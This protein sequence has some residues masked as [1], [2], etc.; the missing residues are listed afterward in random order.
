MR[1]L[2]TLCV[3]FARARRPLWLTLAWSIAGFLLV[4]LLIVRQVSRDPDVI[5]PE[6][7]RFILNNADWALFLFVVGLILGTLPNFLHAW[8]VAHF[9]SRIGSSK[10]FF[11]NHDLSKAVG[12][13]LRL[14]LLD[15]A[16]SQPGDHLPS[17][18]SEIARQWLRKHADS[19]PDL[20]SDFVAK[21]A[22]KPDSP[23]K[24]VFEKTL[25]RFVEKRDAPVLAQG[26]WGKVLTYLNGGTTL[27]FASDAAAMDAIEERLNSRFG[28]A[29]WEYTKDDFV[30]G[31]A[32]SKAMDL[33]I[34]SQ[35]LQRTTA[36]AEGIG[37]LSTALKDLADEW[38]K[39]KDAV[40]GELRRLAKGQRWALRL[41]S[42]NTKAL[43]RI[44]TEIR[45]LANATRE[46]LAKTHKLL[47][48]LGRRGGLSP[49]ALPTDNLTA[50]RVPDNAAKFK[51]RDED[52]D[53]LHR[54]VTSDPHGAPIPVIAAPGVG[55]SALVTRY[56]YLHRNEFDH[57]W[58][59]RASNPEA[60]ASGST[61]E[62]SLAEL[63]DL[64][65]IE[66]NAIQGDAS[67]S[68][69]DALA[70]RVRTWLAR[71]KSDG[72][73]AR[74][75]LVLD[76]VDDYATI[77]RLKLP[78]PS[79][80]I[81]TARAAHLARDGVEAMQLDAL[82]PQD[83][84][85]VLRSRTARWDEAAYADP[86]HEVGELVGRNALALVYLSAVLARPSSQGPAKLRNTLQGALKAG[87][88]GPLDASRDQE[89]PDDHDQQVAEAFALFVEPYKGTSEMAVL[90]VAALCAPD[91]IAVGLVTKASGLEP[92][93]FDG[94]L[95]ELVGAGV[96]DFDDDAISIHRLTQVS[97]VGD[98]AQRGSDDRNA[99][100]T[101]LLDGL[102]EVF[103]WPDDMAGQ[104][105]DHLKTPARFL[106]LAHAESV[107]AHVEESIGGGIRAGEPISRTS[108]AES[109]AKAT[110]LES[111][112]ALLHGE[113]AKW[114]PYVGMLSAAERNVMSAIN[115][116]EKQTP[117]DERSLAIWYRSRASIRQLRGMLKEAEED[118]Q[119]SI[120]WGEKQTP[121]DERSLAID[122]ASRASIR[123]DRGMLEEAEE[124]I[125]KSI[126][127]GEKHTPRDER[128]LA[129]CYASRA[130]ILESRA[131]VSRRS[132][133]AT[134][135]D[136][137]FEKAKAD[138]D[139]AL[140]W[141][142][143][144]MPSDVRSI[145][146]LRADK[147]RINEAAA[148]NR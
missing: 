84:L 112:V 119:K 123:Q 6:S 12:Q 48:E 16:D 102:I 147:A 25:W 81:F 44:E 34:A 79:R 85:L 122:Y 57:V 91:N 29:L 133:D 115:W 99:A 67:T 146:I 62:R 73:H 86:L 43:D 7:A 23:Y 76:N 96:L 83:T 52:L 118:I 8:V 31:G 140:T 66:S 143:T 53:E 69:V 128:G 33:L 72:T 71:P 117:R 61:E 98:M 136:V 1:Y 103:R 101:R 93:A 121:R 131:L 90:D 20:W 109:S 55:K 21:E 14:I 5:L 135:A 50:A 42:A 45:G 129:I 82:S 11:S 106:A 13:S 113:M 58:W 59:V 18:S 104:H 74:H 97:V 54:R 41:L 40:E 27:P 60:R 124:D 63:L 65:G 94:A 145:A 9:N 107:I 87:Q 132:G 92:V 51:G 38:N 95:D 47:E 134:A 148:S 125:A 126:D 28:E 116:G 141:Y 56:V 100:L 120:D 137:L 114:L 2:R 10:T 111:R 4:L 89:R 70:A 19:V 78:S 138:I 130:S 144:L 142:E 22:C 39:H 64:W 36:M 88:T 105:A 24:A 75:L 127:W 37:D 46:N 35:L 26:L 30:N 68:R 110:S 32:E 3:R 139:R 49:S 15:A 17:V 77:A 108:V 80:I